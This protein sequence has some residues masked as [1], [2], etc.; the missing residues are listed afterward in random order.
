[1]PAFVIVIDGNAVQVAQDGGQRSLR[2]R[3]HVH[4]ESPARAGQRGA[5]QQD[6]A[7]YEDQ[8]V[9][10]VPFSSVPR[11]AWFIVAVVATGHRSEK[12][13]FHRRVGP[14]HADG[15]APA[16]AWAPAH[17]IALS[18]FRLSRG[19]TWLEPTLTVEIT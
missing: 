19:V 18:R 3:L 4:V 14:R 15:Q 8:H 16:R 13:R 1:M 17:H 2:A 12:E 10:H 5:A 11:L 7:A 6:A 9:S